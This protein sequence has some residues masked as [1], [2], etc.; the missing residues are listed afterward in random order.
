MS[1]RSNTAQSLYQSTRPD[2][3]AAGGAPRS[4]PFLDLISRST[5]LSLVILLDQFLCPSLC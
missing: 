1:V 2:P 4:V 3:R 5:D